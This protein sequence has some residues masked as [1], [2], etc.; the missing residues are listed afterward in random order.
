MATK[1]SISFLK[2][3]SELIGAI[4]QMADEWETSWSSAA[5]RLIETGLGRQQSHDEDI[6]AALARIE[7]RLSLFQTGHVPETPDD[8]ADMAALAEIKR[9]L[10]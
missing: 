8:A 7:Q 3:K 1:R 9:S 6:A 10:F 5:V 4:R 2:S